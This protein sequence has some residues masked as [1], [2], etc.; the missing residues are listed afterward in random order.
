MSKLSKEILDVFLPEK[1][2]I[3]IEELTSGHI[4]DTYLVKTED[5]QGHYVVQKDQSALF[6]RMFPD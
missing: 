2:I 6:L 3:S 1:E 5:H 4:N